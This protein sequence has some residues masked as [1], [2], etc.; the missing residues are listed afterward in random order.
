MSE[1]ININLK[2][3]ES[4]EVKL[5]V[6]D[7]SVIEASSDSSPVISFVAIG[8]KGANGL[9]GEQGPS[10]SAAIEDGSI[11][12][13]KLASNSITT[14]KIVDL[15]ITT[16]KIANN[17]VTADKIP[18]N[19]VTSN[20]IA[21]GSITED[22]ILDGSITE[23]KYSNNSISEDK[24][25][26]FAVSASKIKDGDVTEVKLHASVS[27]KLN[28]AEA[29]VQADWNE[30]DIN[31]DS[32]IKNKP[33]VPVVT[34][35]LTNE[36]KSDYDNAYTHSQQAHSPSDAEKN[37]QSNWS[38][39]DINDDAYILNKPT[40]P[41]DLTQNGTYEIH[42]NNLS[43]DT[44]V[45]GEALISRGGQA[46]WCSPESLQ[47]Q[48]RNNEG[49]TL[50]LG[51][52]VYSK[53]EIDNMILVGKAD[54]SDPA[55]MPAIGITTSELNTTSNKDGF[56]RTSGV[57]N[58]NISGFSGL[59]VNDSLYV[60]AGGGLTQTHPT[61]EGNLIQNMGII[62]KTNGSICQGLK[63]SSIDRSNAVPNLDDMR[64]FIGDSTNVSDEYTVVAGVNVTIT[65]DEVAKTLTIQSTDT[66]TTYTASSGVS[67]I[68][69]NIE[70]DSSSD[71]RFNSVN[72]F[73]GRIESSDDLELHMDVSNGSSSRKVKF[74]TDST[75][76]VGSVSEAG[77]FQVNGKVT[78]KLTQMYCMSFHGDFGTTKYWM[79]WGNTMEQNVNAYQEEVAM[80]MPYSGRIV[81]C[82]VRTNKIDST[83]NLTIGIE[84]KEPGGLIGQAWDIE[85]T[86]TMSISSTDDNH[87]FHFVFDN[88]EHFQPGDLIAMSIKASIDFNSAS[89][90][91][92]VT[93]VV[94]FDINNPLGTSS[95]EYDT[96]Q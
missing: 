11:E 83:G 59:Q 93:T 60:A 48:I 41:V 25:K 94:E 9:E 91:W 87:A 39:S 74:M 6:G 70:L 61:G 20:A 12:A 65:K 71:A 34:N 16:E 30:I 82:L 33:T 56:V 54:A 51:T 81:S 23:N 90:Y 47:L 18:S 8:D 14:D 22:K 4:P 58:F 95:A 36:L 66:D 40:I 85:E 5:T 7:S 89:T 86:E 72:V 24:I 27:S 69:T 43:A 37:V 77:D 88:Q 64:I 45:D 26:D 62:L 49:V 55:K 17:S 31:Q 53:G 50:P 52:P 46:V 29:N 32:F 84:T 2:S 68:G 42:A 76:E 28:N 1:I 96:S 10:G 92:F 38:E 57:Y 78:G 79:P 44:P 13:V 75:V 21:T 73:N 67:I 19:A 63:V 35:D 15:N 3:S 80:S